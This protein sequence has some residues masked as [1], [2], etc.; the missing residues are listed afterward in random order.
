MPKVRLKHP[1][2]HLFLALAGFVA[3]VVMIES[4]GLR[5]W[6]ERLEPGPL[7]SVAQP[8]TASIDES[9]RPLG[10][11]AIRDHVLNEMARLGWTDDPARL[12]ANARPAEAQS[13]KSQTD[14]SAVASAPKPALAA[15]AIAPAP[16]GTPVLPLAPMLPRTTA[17]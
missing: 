3:A 10:I 11:G 14:N 1:I 16:R 9:L 17:L 5:N 15:A 2:R 13:A 12:A 7:R 4:D 8:V 6:A